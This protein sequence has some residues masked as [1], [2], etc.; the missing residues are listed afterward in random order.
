MPSSATD[1]GSLLILNCLI[2]DITAVQM[3]SRNFFEN[4]Q[5]IY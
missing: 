1:D 4:F 3:C 2:D 5:Q